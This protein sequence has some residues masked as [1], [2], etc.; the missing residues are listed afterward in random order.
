MCYTLFTAIVNP[1]GSDCDE[2]VI[3][4][5]HGTCLEE[6]SVDVICICDNGWSSSNCSQNIDDC[7][8]GRCSN[9]GTCTD[10]VDG[11]TC[12]CHPAWTGSTC[13]SS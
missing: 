10:Q 3:C 12:S 8:E 5:G 4:S 7:T 11:F 2:A 13:D 9:G 1:I 6:I